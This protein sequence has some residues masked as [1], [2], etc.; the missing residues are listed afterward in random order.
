[1]ATDNFFSKTWNKVSIYYIFISTYIHHRYCKAVTDYS[2]SLYSFSILFLFVISLFFFSASQRNKKINI[3]LTVNEWSSHCI[4]VFL[5]LAGVI[6][7]LELFFFLLLKNKIKHKGLLQPKERHRILWTEN[8]YF[9]CFELE[10]KDANSAIPHSF[11]PHLRK[12]Q[13]TALTFSYQITSK[14]ATTGRTD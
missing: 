10:F 9:T 1:M 12:M 2:F 6:W 5:L 4:F 8:L 3:L 11:S 13:R 7:L 14:D